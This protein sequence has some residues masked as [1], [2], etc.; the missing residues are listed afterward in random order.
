M[1]FLMKNKIKQALIEYLDPLSNEY[2]LTE[3]NIQTI[4]LTDDKSLQLSLNLGFLLGSHESTFKENLIHYLKLIFT[5]LAH[6]DVMLG[7]NVQPHRIATQITRI[8]TI[9]NI[10]AISSG[11]GGVG[12]STTTVNLALALKQ[13]GA[14][15]G[16]LD[17]DIYGPNQPMMLGINDK[18]EIIDQNKFKPL[19]AY[20]IQVMSIGFLVDAEQPMVWRGPMA[21]GA[22]QQLINDTL[23]HDLDY[24]LID[25]PPGTGDIHLT[26]SQKTPITAA[27]VVTTPQDIALLDARKGIEMFNK[28]KVPMLGII[29]NM[30]THICS[31]CGYEEH[32]FG[33]QGAEELAKI[34]KL[35]VL[36]QLPLDIKIREGADNGKPTV[37]AEPNSP[38]AKLYQMVALKMAI[39]ISLL[40]KDY[41]AKLPG[42]VVE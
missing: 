21:T 29:E 16:I 34:S 33:T 14:K 41:S 20:G 30:S 25:M 27:V 24:L 8:P 17:A 1:K 15:I 35:E 31:Q 26:L 42:V 10:I 13:L 39:K 22:L 19:T 3:K 36:G 40:G 28:V 23:W 38:V 6:I 37:I 32:L 12:K 11:K 18:P 4:E 7:F 5:H 2:V 9:K